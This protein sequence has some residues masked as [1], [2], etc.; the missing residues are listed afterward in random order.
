MKVRMG[1]SQLVCLLFCASQ[2]I[3]ERVPRNGDNHSASL[4]VVYVLQQV[5]R[6]DST[7]N[8]PVS[9]RAFPWRKSL[10]SLGSSLRSPTKHSVL[11]VRAARRLSSVLLWF[12]SLGKGNT[13][14]GTSA[15][16][17]N[18]VRLGQLTREPGG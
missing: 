7:R 11:E 8:F 2:S 13:S 18:L 17:C 1:L 9:L 6:A 14:L 3:Q 5:I 12:L 10:C 15:Q 16:G 4:P